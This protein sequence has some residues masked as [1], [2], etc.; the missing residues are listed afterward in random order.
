[1]SS[2]KS[3][4]D[5]RGAATTEN[6]LRALAKLGQAVWLDYIR[7]DLITTG[8]LARLIAEDDL[9][10]MTSNPSIFE[11]AITGSKEYADLLQQ[12]KKEKNLDATA[13]YERLAI[14][15]IQDAADAH[16]R[17]VY[18]KTQRRDGYVSLEVSPYLAHKTPETI[19]E[20]Q[21]LWK[22]VGR[23]NVMIAGCPGTPGACRRFLN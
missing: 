10:G 20:A 15:D 2:P 7:R 13:I 19:A 1:M 11:K 12:L 23:E 3:T 17:S 9:R 14:R 5:V 4:P 22:T 8:E 16:H 21:R 6:P 18:D